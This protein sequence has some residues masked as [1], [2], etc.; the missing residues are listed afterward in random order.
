[1]SY[2]ALSVRTLPVHLSF[3]VYILEVPRYIAEGSRYDFS[4][5]HSSQ[6]LKKS[7]TCSLL[8]KAFQ[9]VSSG[10]ATPSLSSRQGSVG[11]KNFIWRVF[12]LFYLKP[13]WTIELCRLHPKICGLAVMLTFF[14]LFS[15][16][17][18][19]QQAVMSPGLRI[20]VKA[21]FLA[22]LPQ[23]LQPIHL[24]SLL[25]SSFW[26]K[27][28]HKA[29]C[30]IRNKYEASPPQVLCSKGASK[31]NR[32]GKDQYEPAVNHG[33]QTTYNGQV[34]RG[35]LRNFIGCYVLTPDY[36]DLILRVAGRA[37]VYR[38]FMNFKT[39]FSRESPL[40]TRYYNGKEHSFTS[41]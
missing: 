8:F 40:Y 30:A 29:W 36:C 15:S 25:S 19:H 3:S 1:M 7:W 27:F 22:I 5:D 35:K 23:F 34:C 21:L 38:E 26:L 18:T 16:L 9:S 14:G 20:V 31:H 24:F 17:E 32:A 12:G 33:F 11:C 4:L 39:N 2:D 13:L 28:F 10:L 37:Q 6:E 41:I